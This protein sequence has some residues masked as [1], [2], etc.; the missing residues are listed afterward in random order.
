MHA[1]RYQQL[2][3]SI[4]AAD[5]ADN[6]EEEEEDVARITIDEGKQKEKAEEGTEEENC[7]ETEWWS[8]RV[9]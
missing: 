4:R 6:A 3:M 8:S 9:I 7:G 2:I 1:Q 5:K